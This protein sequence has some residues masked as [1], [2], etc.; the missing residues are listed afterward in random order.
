MVQQHA[1]NTGYSWQAHPA[2]QRPTQ[3]ALALGII[4]M[5]AVAV[6]LTTQSIIWAAG[7]GLLLVSALN[8]FF[9]PSRFVIDATGI[10]AR[11]PFKSARLEWDAVRR[12]HFDTFGGY[13]SDIATPSRFDAF[14]GLHVLFGDDRDQAISAI[15]QRVR[16]CEDTQPTHA[17]GTPEHA[18]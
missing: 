11:Y 1:D 7:S 4:A 3:A 10:T 13:L 9:L 6:L 2:R 8:R 18:P 16:S 14:R 5:F 12:A 17:A 15:R